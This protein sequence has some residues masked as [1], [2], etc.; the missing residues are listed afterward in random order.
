M[1]L[2]ACVRTERKV[3]NTWETH[4]SVFGGIGGGAWLYKLFHGLLLEHSKKLLSLNMNLRLLTAD[5]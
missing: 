1:L 5:G 2:V 3:I 4:G